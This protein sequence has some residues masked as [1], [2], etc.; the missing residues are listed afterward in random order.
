MHDDAPA[1]RRVRWWRTWVAISSFVFLAL[2]SPVTNGQTPPGGSLSGRVTLATR[3]RGVPLS[4]NAY[5]PRAVSRQESS[6]TPEMLN[7]VVYLKERG[8]RGPLPT[9]RRQIRQERETFVPRVIA[10]TRGSTLDF[11]N[12][13]PFFHNVFSLSGAGSF[14]LGRYPDGES[15]SRQ[16]TK[17]GL[18][19]VF[20]HIHSHMSASILVLDHP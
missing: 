10:V 7:V 11:P 2:L 18:V 6:A 12:A 1:A 15:R 16:F 3:I 8:Y 4:T 20:C 5:T 17:A 19:K 13:D 14:D 9:T